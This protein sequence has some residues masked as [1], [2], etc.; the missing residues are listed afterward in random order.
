MAFN[1]KDFN[2]LEKQKPIGGKVK[3]AYGF[4]FRMF[5]D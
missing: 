3:S 4:K 1:I 5:F 2:L